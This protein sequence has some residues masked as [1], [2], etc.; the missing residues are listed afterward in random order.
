MIRLF[1]S[2]DYFWFS[3]PRFLEFFFISLLFTLTFKFGFLLKFFYFIYSFMLNFFSRL[4]LSFSSITKS[5]FFSIIISVLFLNLFSVF[6]YNFAHTSQISLIFFMGL[7]VWLRFLIFF[8]FN[9]IKGL[10]SHFIPDGRPV[11]LV[12]VLFIIEIVRSVIRPIT[13]RVRLVANILAGHLLLV[14]LSKVVYSFSLTFPLHFVL[15]SVE[16]FVSL[17][18]SYIFVTMLTLYYCD[19]S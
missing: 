19:V 17:I 12:P 9:N 15:S 3:F 10:L 8:L 2:F 7:G 16:I 18:Q 6:P 1:S 13:L 14:L 11:I 5:F 4:K